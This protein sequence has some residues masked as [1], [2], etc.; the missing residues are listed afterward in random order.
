MAGFAL[1]GI[2]VTAY[3]PN[4]RPAVPA[5][6]VVILVLIVMADIWLVIIL[7]IGVANLH[8]M[9]APVTLV[10]LCAALAQ[11]MTANPEHRR[12]PWIGFT[13]GA[14]PYLAA[15]LLQVTAFSSKL[16]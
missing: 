9:Y 14:A 4:S 10:L 6:S 3:F 1:L 12:W 5:W 11:R 2:L 8:H 16:G 7:G 13:L 15:T